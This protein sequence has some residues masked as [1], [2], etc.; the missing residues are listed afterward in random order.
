MLIVPENVKEYFREVEQWAT[1]NK[2]RDKFNE[3]MLRAH[4]YGCS[5][6]DPERA[7]VTLYSKDFAFHSFLFSIDFRNKD[8]GYNL[9][10]S[11]GL[12]FSGKIKNN[13]L[14]RVDEHTGWRMHT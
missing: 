3:A 8:G 7:R 14:V 9:L 10:M 6:E 4:L 11:G 5:W 2:I 1:D 13:R 12:I